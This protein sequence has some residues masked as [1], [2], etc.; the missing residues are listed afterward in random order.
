M[1]VALLIG[2][3][4]SVA[5]L[6]HHAVVEERARRK[7]KWIADARREGERILI[8]VG[9]H[10]LVPDDRYTDDDVASLHQLRAKVEQESGLAD[11]RERATDLLEQALRRRADRASRASARQRLQDFFRRR[12]EALFLDVELTG[13]DSTGDVQAVRESARAALDIFAAAGTEGDGWT[14]APPTS[15]LPEPERDEVIPG[16]NEM[17]MVLAEATAQPRPG[18]SPQRQAR[19]AIR[20]LDRAAALRPRPTHAYHLRRAAYLERAGDSE[21]AMSERAMARRIQPDGAFDHFLSGLERYKRGL[22]AEARQHF[23]TALQAQPDYFW[24]QCLLA[25]C[26]LNARPAHP[27]QA[28]A[29][30]TAC[31]QTHPDLPWLYLLRGFAFGQ[32]AAAAST[33]AEAGHQFDAAE[34]DFREAFRRDPDGRF[35]YALLANRGLIRFRGGRWEDAAADLREAIGLNPRQYSAHV[36]LAQVYRKQHKLDLALEQLGLAIALTPDAADLRRTRALWNLERPDPTAAVRAAALLDLEEA[37]RRDPPG[38]RELATDHAKRGYALLLDGRLAE[39]LD[40]CEAALYIHPDDAEARRLRL[41][42][43]L[44]LKRYDQVIDACD[45]YLRSGPPSPEWLELR[46]L[47]KVKRND[48][49]GAIEDYTVALSL[50]PGA[51][52]LYCLRGWAYLVSGAAPLA[53]RDFDEAIRRDPSSGEAYGGRGAALIALGRFREGAAD[54]EESARRGATVPR[55]LY[56]AARTMAQAASAASGEAGRRGRGDVLA[57]RRYQDRALQLLGQ[58]LQRTAADQRATFWRDVV[59]TD[60]A[61]KI[62]RRLPG[63]ARV[64]AEYETPRRTPP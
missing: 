30:L 48:F 58:A 37:I 45:G 11:L 21:R 26:D 33:R 36:T 32:S 22:L 47:A 25:I 34:A 19:E 40:A 51:S 24:A 39:A 14:L 44:E 35:R 27:E 59:Q 50:Q 2:S 53:W 64:A 42:A 55:T 31:L 54:A 61:L 29:Y 49:A 16:C 43:L 13:P 23:R 4:A 46:G 7:A 20:I 3:T 28:E 41:T 57:V 6:R 10:L 8:E 17:L 38:S 62:I 60:Q 52:N 15:S 9:N 18:E 1:A 63:Y 5:G 12:D 56:N